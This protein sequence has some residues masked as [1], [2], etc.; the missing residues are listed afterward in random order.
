MGTLMLPPDL[1]ARLDELAREKDM[2]V[3]EFLWFRLQQDTPADKRLPMPAW[4]RELREKL[5][6]MARDYWRGAGDEARLALTDAQLDRQFWLI[7]YEGIPRL[8]E[9]QG[10][11]ELP[12]DPLEQFIG[13]IEDADP[14]LSMSVRETLEERFGH[15]T[16]G[17]DDAESAA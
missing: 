5:Y 15:S 2:S 8:L 11:V 3:E 1:I 10:K 12:P 9:D 6:N 7:D 4:E 13:V 16:S 14:N 17:R